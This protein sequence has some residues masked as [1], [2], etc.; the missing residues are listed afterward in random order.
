MHTDPSYPAFP[1]FSLLGAILVLI[2]LP[3]HLQAWNSGTCLFMIWTAVASLNLFINSLVWHGNVNNVAPLWCDI[4]SRLVVGAAV[5][6]PAAS[7]CINRRLHAI[8]S[9]Q[10]T[11]VTRAEKKRAVI[12]DLSIGLGIPLLQ[13][14]LQ[15]IVSGHRFDIIEDVGCYP[16]TFNTPPAYPLVTAWPLAISLVSACYGALTLRAFFRQR[17]QFKDVVSSHSSLTVNRYFRLM[18]LATMEF[19]ITIPICSYGIYLGLSTNS[20]SPWRGWADTHFD[21]GQIGQV[22]SVLWRMNRNNEI[23]IELTRWSVV[24]TAFVFFGFFG[25]AMEARK[26][27]H[28]AYLFV[29]QRLGL[30]PK[31]AAPALPSAMYWAKPPPTSSFDL[32]EKSTPTLVSHVVPKALPPPKCPSFSASSPDSSMAFFQSPVSGGFEVSISKV[33]YPSRSSSPESHLEHVAHPSP[34]HHV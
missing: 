27:Y 6:I 24:F 26:N 11:T 29:A 9:I 19:V 15:I 21:Y 34:T 4:S 7:L 13:M 30:Q 32:S 10:S 1:I 3:W 31:L 2:P 18:A 20:V 17:A 28:K 25:F 16:F 22:P 12:I 8:A 5:A 14:I 23:S 33:R